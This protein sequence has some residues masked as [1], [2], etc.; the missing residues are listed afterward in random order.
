MHRKRL[1][2]LQLAHDSSSSSSTNQACTSLAVQQQLAGRARW[3]LPQS[4]LAFCLESSVH[5]QTYSAT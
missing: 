3:F 2:L 5:P 1:Q 4:R